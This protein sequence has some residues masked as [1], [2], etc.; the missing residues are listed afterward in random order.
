VSNI[1]E[2]ERLLRSTILAGFAAAGLTMSPVYAQQQNDDEDEQSEEDSEDTIVVT[3]SRIRRDAFASVAPLQTIDSQEIRDAGLIDTAQILQTSS[4]AQGVQLDNTIGGAFVTDAGPGSNTITLRGLNADQTLLLING[5]RVAPSGVEGAPSLP[6][7]DIIP[8]DAIQ[9]IDILLDGASS[10]YGSDAVAG[11]VNVILRDNFEGFQ[12]GAYMNSPEQSGGGSHR[13]N[14]MVGDSSENGRFMFSME[15]FH[16]DDLE[17]ADRD[18]NYDPTDGLYCSR[19]IEIAADGSVLSEC[20]GSIINRIR[21][22]NYYVDGNP[23]LASY[24]A[25]PGLFGTDVYSTPGTTDT[26]IMGWSFGNSANE[27]YRSSYLDQTTDIIPDSQRYSFL[28]TGDYTIDR[29]L[30]QDNVTIFTELLHTNSQTTYKSGYHGQIF[31]TVNASNPFNPFGFD[32]VPIFASPVSRSNIDVETQYTRFMSGLQGDWS[33]MPSWS[34]EFFGGYT[35]SM[36]YSNRPQIDEERLIAT[37][38]TSRYEGGQIVCGYDTSN[39]ELFGFLSPSN[40]VPVNLFHP[41]LYPNDGVTAPHFGSEAEREYLEINRTATTIVDQLIFGGFTT[42]PLFELPAGEVSGVFGIEWRR[43]SLD[44]GTDTVTSQGRAAG[45]FA[46]RRSVGSAELTEYYGEL[47]IP[48]VSGAPFAEDISLELA[49]RLTDHEYYGQNSTYSARASWVVTDFLTFNATTGTSFRAPNLR[50]LFLGGQTGF[51]SGF[52]DPCVVPNAARGP[53]NTYDPTNDNRD[54]VV[55][56]NC[57]AEGVDPTSLGLTGT[58]SI[59]SFRA[60]NP[61][62]EPE[63]SDAMSIGFVFDQPF[64][65]RFDAS[66][67]VSYFS[68]EVEDSIAIP[69]TAFSLGQC[70]NSTNFPNDPFC[71]RRQRDAN[72]GLLTFVDNTPFNVATQETT[73]W[74]Y[75]GRFNMDFDFLG[76]FNYDMNATFTKSEEILNRTTATSDLLNFVGDWGNPEWRGSISNRFARGDWSVLWRARYLGEQASIRNVVGVDYGDRIE[77][78]SELGGDAVDSWDAVWYHDLSVSLDR[79]TWAVTF[80]VNNLF[81]E[82]PAIIDQDASGATL[83]SGNEVLGSGY[84]LLGRR[85]FARVSKAW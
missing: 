25:N 28:F 50:E 85:F 35:R 57:V 83:G 79:D 64:T 17:V 33:F 29:F 32:V 30:G 62:L 39:Y 18:W 6:N 45:Y 37:I 14:M 40:C 76:G 48:I 41:N 63:T 38:A 51:T 71:A 44:S 43:D 59:E 15:Y 53:G 77:A 55:L 73:G 24:F 1:W 70:Y 81:N 82:E 66:V 26:G 10:V 67:R 11:V 22:Y 52:A 68:I 9:R 54:A 16:Q 4:V 20:E 58:P 5:R 56:A 27:A 84:D 72:T 74:D 36:G 65:D 60:G 7:V 19:D 75:N 8:T 78:A 2:R 21:T 12:V 34:Y 42:G 13:W 49:G 23:D 46:D 31:G 80:G 3:G 61:G 47:A 69:G